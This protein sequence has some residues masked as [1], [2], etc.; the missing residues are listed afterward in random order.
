MKRQTRTDAGFILITSIIFMLVL[1]VVVVY[2]VRS[3]TVYERV[4]GNNRNRSMAVQSA[5]FGL[6]ES[7]AKL[8]SELY[9]AGKV[10]NPVSRNLSADAYA[11]FND[12]DHWTNSNSIEVT[13]D[14]TGTYSK[15]RYVV[16][17]ENVAAA[18]EGCNYYGVK[19]LGRGGNSNSVVVLDAV[20]KRCMR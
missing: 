7:Q 13:G 20:V 6:R 12:P 5:E 10:A 11:A 4:A 17:N 9:V 15:P 18:E 19:S 16:R 2:A 1:T 3:A 14:I 8:L